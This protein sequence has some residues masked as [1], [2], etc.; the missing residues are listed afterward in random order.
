MREVTDTEGYPYERYRLEDLK[1]LV[2]VNV[3]QSTDMWAHLKTLLLTLQFEKAID[4]IYSEQNSLLESTHF[5]IALAYHG[6]LKIPSEIQ[7]DTDRKMRKLYITCM[8][9]YAKHVL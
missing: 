7:A 3:D 1:K 9:M 6:L 2:S 5:A 8:Y 4:Y